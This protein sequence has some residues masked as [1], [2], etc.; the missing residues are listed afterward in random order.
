MEYAAKKFIVGDVTVKIV[1]DD[2]FIGWNHHMC[3]E[4]IDVFGC[5]RHGFWSIHAG[6][7][8]VPDME[9]CRNICDNDWQ[10]IVACNVQDFAEKDDGRVIV[11]HECYS[12]AVTYANMRNAAR[13]VLRR[14]GFDLDSIR[15]RTL[16]SQRDLI[17]CAWNQA[18]LDQYAGVKNAKGFTDYI[19]HVLDNDIWG[20]VINDS[21]GEYL[22]SCWGFVG[23]PDNDD[24]MSEARAAAEYQSDMVRA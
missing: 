9:I 24:L 11:Y 1:K 5:G 8:D 13:G 6:G 23:N 22:D 14:Q 20:F 3:D 7:A 21:D 4:P 12:Y 10:E 15:V 2:D 18:Q 17:F 19:Q 16:R